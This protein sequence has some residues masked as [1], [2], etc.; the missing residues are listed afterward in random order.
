MHGPLRDDGAYV[1]IRGA[2]SVPRACG[3]G[4]CG[5]IFTGDVVRARSTVAAVCE[6]R[7]YT[8][9]HTYHERGEVRWHYMDVTNL[10]QLSDSFHAW[11]FRAAR[12]H[13]N[14]FLSTALVAE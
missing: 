12:V 5:D 7:T 14:C 1:T 10:G 3:P 11:P 8:L 13:M 2:S 9:T 6:S 4:S